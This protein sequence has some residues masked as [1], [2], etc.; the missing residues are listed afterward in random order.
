MGRALIVRWGWLT[1]G[2]L[3]AC[4][5]LGAWVVARDWAPGASGA[6]M[7]AY[8]ANEEVFPSVHPR[9]GCPACGVV[10]LGR[11]GPS[12]WRVRVTARQ[13]ASCFVVYTDRARRD[14]NGVHGVRAT[15]CR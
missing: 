11:A 2:L 3:A 9:P 10:I 1:A 14:A 6:V 8:S 15:S 5:G 12:A 4:V 13:Q 7:E